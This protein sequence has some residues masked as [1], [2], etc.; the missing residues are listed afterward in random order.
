MGIAIEHL[1]VAG[2]PD[3]RLGKVV[4]YQRRNPQPA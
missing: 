4:R 2:V 3:Q 1:A